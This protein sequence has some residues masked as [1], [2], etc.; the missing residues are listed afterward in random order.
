MEDKTKEELVEM[1]KNSPNEF[2][3]WKQTQEDVDLIKR[4]MKVH[5]LCTEYL[6]QKKT[7]AG[8]KISD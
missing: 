6:E 5:K 1:L 7:F 8:K 4:K 2:N 3:E